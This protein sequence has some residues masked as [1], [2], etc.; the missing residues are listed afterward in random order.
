MTQRAA[1]GLASGR[2]ATCALACA[3][4]GALVS[5][6][7]TTM[8]YGQPPAVERL[9]SLQ[10][11][12]SSKTDILSVLG[13]PRG[14]GAARFSP[15]LGYREA[16]FYEYA[17]SDGKRVRLKFLLVFLDHDRYDGYLWFSSAELMQ[18]IQ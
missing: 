8:K 2:I 7:A 4:A 10:R 5:G 13:E 16:L 3:L 9:Q 14:L 15:A 18:V 1:I 17:E 6:C 12:A 11:G